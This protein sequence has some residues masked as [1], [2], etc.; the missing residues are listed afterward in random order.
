MNIR[1]KTF[2]QPL[3]VQHMLPRAEIPTCA[4]FNIA[5]VLIAAEAR[6]AVQPNCPIV[7][8]PVHP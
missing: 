1:Q 4:L 6:T 7:M 5:M 2:V 3:R 8:N